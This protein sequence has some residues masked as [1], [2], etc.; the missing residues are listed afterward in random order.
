MLLQKHF[1]THH[2]VVEQLVT[3]VSLLP[4]ARRRTIVQP[5]EIGSVCEGSYELT[6]NQTLAP[7]NDPVASYLVGHQNGVA[8]VVVGS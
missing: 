7:G 3:A 5:K 4:L 1:L 8:E 2:C 6:R